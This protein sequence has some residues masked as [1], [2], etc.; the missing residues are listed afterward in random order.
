[1][2]FTNNPMFAITINPFVQAWMVYAKTGAEIGRMMM[3]ANMEAAA[4]LKQVTQLPKM[5]A[6]A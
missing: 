3:V 1:M 5:T 2:P 4:A 6:T